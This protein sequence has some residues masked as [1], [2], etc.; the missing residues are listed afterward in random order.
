MRL[1]S[2]RESVWRKQQT[3]EKEK[4]CF[5]QMSSLNLQSMLLSKA[6]MGQNH[7]TFL[8]PDALRRFSLRTGKALEK[9][10][11]RRT[12]KEPRIWSLT[13]EG[14]KAGASQ[15]LGLLSAAVK[16]N[17]PAPR[18]QPRGW[19]RAWRCWHGVE[20]PPTPP[21][22]CPSAGSKLHS[23]PRGATRIHL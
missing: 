17:A 23:S 1:Q 21:I 15:T 18:G 5:T 3:H 12:Q 20:A 11:R 22:A 14:R 16:Q 9:R 13:W 6:V 10:Q 2:F 4:L 19:P 7:F 8:K